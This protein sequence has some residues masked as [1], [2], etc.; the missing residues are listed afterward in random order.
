[1]LPTRGVPLLPKGGVPLAAMGLKTES[2]GARGLSQEPSWLLRQKVSRE[3][4]SAKK[5][6]KRPVR[7]LNPGLPRDRRGY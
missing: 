2:H 3:P 4:S 1:M 7:E 5:A 6:K